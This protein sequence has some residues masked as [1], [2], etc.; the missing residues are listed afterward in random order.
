MTVDNKKSFSLNSFK[1]ALIGGGARPNL[2]VV[3]MGKVPALGTDFG[4]N[5]KF[6]CKAASLPASN[7]ASIDV[8]FRG[9][10]FKVAG[11]RTVENWT[12]TIINDEDF[13]IRNIMEDWMQNIVKL[14]NNTGATQPASY[15]GEA[16]VVQLGRNAITGAEQG[17]K[18]KASGDSFTND[19]QDIKNLAQY[20]FQ[21]IW[22]V[23][24]SAI[25]LSYDNSDQIEE[26]T[27]E[28]AVQS[29]SRAF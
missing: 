21:D 1:S 16:D 15:M 27:V 9:R 3:T 11:D 28:F 6:M 10:I 5:F 8:P 22:P 18:G 19:E 12:V 2:F 20:K 14:E 24:I 23:N 7:I 13:A 4:T 25:D 26:F 29:Y 17:G